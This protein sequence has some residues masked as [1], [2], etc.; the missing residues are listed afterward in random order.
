MAGAL[1]TLLLSAGWSVAL[2]AR[3]SD[4][5]PSLSLSPVEAGC[6]VGPHVLQRIQN[7]L[8]LDRSEDVITVPDAPNYLGSF[9][10][11]SHSGPWDYLQTVPL[12]AYG[13]KH[14]PARG[15]LDDEV[16][17]A[18]VYPTVEDWTQT[19]LRDRA[20][21]SLLDAVEPAKR[22]PKLLVFIMWDGVGRNVLER[23]PGR[24]PNLERLEREG[25][26]YVEA[27][28]GSSPSI[29]PATH[30]TLGTGAFP[31]EHGMT[32]IQYRGPDGEIKVAFG[33][34]EPNDLELTTFADDYDRALGNEPK[35]GLVGLRIWHIPMMGHGAAT[36]GGDRDHLALIGFD[37]TINGNQDLYETPRYLHGFPG[38]QRHIDQLDE[39]DGVKD[40]EWR[41][42]P[43]ATEHDNPAW[44]RYQTDVI[45]ETW[46][47]EAYG[48]DATPDMFFINYK[49]TDIVGHQYSMDSEEMGDMLQAQDE[50]LGKILNYL[51]KKIR[52]YVLVLSA[53]HGHTPAPERS[54]AWPINAQELEDDIH[55][56]F[57][58]KGAPLIQ[59]KSAVGLFIDDKV[60]TQNE[61]T[62][63]N[64]ALYLNSYTIEENSP[65]GDVPHSHQDRRD[66]LVF[67][68]VFPAAELEKV[69]A[70]AAG[71]T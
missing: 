20:G 12:V 62:D 40:G 28:V 52:D 3:N 25:T 33:A 8:R 71:R 22:P 38:L 18:D 26:S 50:E 41:G 19:E 11:T 14:V 53:D 43:I 67:E 70:C 54:G 29:T 57:D 48:R 23:W 13:P 56:H 1:L 65:K 45:F 59:Q 61:V 30:A 36:Q 47:R 42:H 7:G 63:D 64:I 69:L 24:W 21:S 2:W 37:Q 39:R 15:S 58:I 5:G 44:A 66:E 49:M 60:A 27:T 9:A 32:G 51:D 6:Q 46:N 35:I 34:R 68:A 55:R 17:L 10:V 4:S 16:T 31:N